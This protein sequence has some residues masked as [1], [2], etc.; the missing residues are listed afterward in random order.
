MVFKNKRYKISEKIKWFVGRDYLELYHPLINRIEKIEYQ[1]I[2][3]I[4]ITITC[5]FDFLSTCCALQDFILKSSVMDLFNLLIRKGYI[6]TSE[7]V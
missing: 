3:I 4:W 5:N 6:V 7:E 2:H 1:D